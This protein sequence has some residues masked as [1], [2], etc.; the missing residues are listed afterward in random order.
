VWSP[1][2][3]GTGSMTPSEYC[4]AVR[5]LLAPGALS[6]GNSVGVQLPARPQG[7]AAPTERRPCVVVGLLSESSLTSNVICDGS[8]T[9]RVSELVPVVGRLQP[10]KSSEPL[11]V[12]LE[13]LTFRSW[14]RWFSEEFAL[15]VRPLFS[16]IG[17]CF[18]VHLC[19]W[20]SSCL[21]VVGTT[22]TWPGSRY[23][24]A[25]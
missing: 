2:A 25:C 18:C 23:C 16:C 22:P 9:V 13:K 19:E 21:C 1:P 8:A 3:A 12:S 11:S 7:R 24:S 10:V 14:D 4:N 17:V 15:E 6:P 5:R 20:A